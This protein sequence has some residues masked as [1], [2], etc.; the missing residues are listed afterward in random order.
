MLLSVL[1][2][3]KDETIF[4]RVT[5]NKFNF[6][7]S[8]H[9]V[10]YTFY[11]T[12]HFPG[13]SLSHSINQGGSSLQPCSSTTS[14]MIHHH[15]SSYHQLNSTS[16]SSNSAASL[17]P[18]IVPCSSG[19]TSLYSSNNNGSIITTV[20]DAHSSTTLNMHFYDSMTAATS[21]GAGSG[22][23]GMMSGKVT[24]EWEDFHTVPPS[25]DY[26]YV[27]GYRKK[28]TEITV[29]RGRFNLKLGFLE[30]QQFQ[31]YFL[32]LISIPGLNSFSFKSN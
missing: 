1:L 3:I 27:L 11:L 24:A 9:V 23:V 32:A 8:F 4:D 21:S 5:N 22:V 28:I 7:S 12:M 2:A 29:K 17:M 6:K 13:M 25:R 16:P 26:L 30:N 15:S 19:V 18:P 31:T 10:L 20:G 14:S